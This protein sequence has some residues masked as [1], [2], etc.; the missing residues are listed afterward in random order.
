MATVEEIDSMWSKDCKIDRN[1]L[2]EETI[3]SGILHQKYLNLLMSAKN[4]LIKLT[5]DYLV[6]K[7]LRTRYYLG[8]LTKEELEQYGWPQYQG[9]KPL[10]SD[11]QSKLDTDSE[12]LKIKLKIQ[13]LENIQYQ[14]ESI[15]Q[16]I[17]NRDWA[18]KSHIEWLKYASGN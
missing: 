13:Y 7:D 6:M 16:Q 9:L 18:I 8:E 11:M 12:L 14:L 5:N 2:T 1:N 15:L 10:K 3:R 17:R 4:K